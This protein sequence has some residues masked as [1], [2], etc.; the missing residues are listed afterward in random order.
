M[1]I[2]LLLLLIV[3]QAA[4]LPGRMLMESHEHGSGSGSGV[5][6][7]SGEGV[8][9]H[10]S[11][12]PEG[13]HCHPEHSM[14]GANGC[15]PTHSPPPPPVSPPPAIVVRMELTAAGVLE[16]FEVGTANYANTRTTVA[17]VC[18]VSND[19]VAVQVSAGSVIIKA[20]VT[21]YSSTDAEVAKQ[22]LRTSFGTKTDAAEML[23]Y[24]VETD[25]TVTIVESD[26]DDDDT[27]TVIG[28]A[29]G[30][31]V[32]IPLVLIVG[33]FIFKKTQPIAKSALVG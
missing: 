16:D 11:Q 13:S 21:T 6:D 9:S 17:Q 29:V 19:A 18:E 27:A 12:C 3:G 31:G 2:A 32:G 33:Y 10:D 5:F 7:G 15:M 4:A 24:P 25:P 22:K 8:C 20:D 26:D 1:A 23:G 14:A 28:L 30:L